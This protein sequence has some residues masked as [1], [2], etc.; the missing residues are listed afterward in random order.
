[1]R[2]IEGE[3]KNLF[4]VHI[5]RETDKWD[6]NQLHQSLKQF[7]QT[8]NY[9]EYG[10]RIEKFFSSRPKN[11]EDIFSFMSRIDKYKEEIE[12]LNFLFEK[13]N[14]TVRIPNFFHVWKILSSLDTYPEY[15]IYTEKIQQMEQSEWI[16]L[17]L[18]DIRHELHKLHSNKVQMEG[19][20][21]GEKILGLQTVWGENPR[22]ETVGREK[23]N[24]YRQKKER[25]LT[26]IR[27]PIQTNQHI[28]E[29]VCMG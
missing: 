9:K 29:G 5:I 22:T 7:L 28:P 11:G 13:E 10:E 6:I 14:E 3:N 4:C 23:T 18:T 24:T 16:K 2:S 25:S 8:E 15:R 26:P 21:T 12:R 20:E 17:K 27:Q 19:K 1:M